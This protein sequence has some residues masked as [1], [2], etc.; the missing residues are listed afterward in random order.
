MDNGDSN[1]RTT[2]TDIEIAKKYLTDDPYIY[3]F[4]R[5]ICVSDRTV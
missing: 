3:T 1:G 4:L 5:M 2:R